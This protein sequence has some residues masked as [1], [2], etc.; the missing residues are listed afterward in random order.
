MNIVRTEVIEAV[1]CNEHRIV[2]MLILSLFTNICMSIAEA[3]M[4]LTNEVRKQ[5][6]PN[7][8]HNV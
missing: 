8:S 3:H 1:I 7:N 5:D 4:K 6:A 2:T